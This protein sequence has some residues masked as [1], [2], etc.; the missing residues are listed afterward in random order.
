M[1]LINNNFFKE[2]EILCVQ[3]EVR[4]VLSLLSVAAAARVSSCTC[5]RRGGSRRSTSTGSRCGGELEISG[6]GGEADDKSG[7]GSGCGDVEAG[8]GASGAGD[9]GSS[10]TA[11]LPST[12]SSSSS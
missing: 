7:S 11:G 1:G 4:K 6:D 10:T 2:Q 9:D 12:H 5:S 3:L 8:G